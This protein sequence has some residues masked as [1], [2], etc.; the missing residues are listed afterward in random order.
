MNR[1]MRSS[2]ILNANK[3]IQHEVKAIQVALNQMNHLIDDQI[4]S[5]ERSKLEIKD[6]EAVSLKSNEFIK[7]L[8]NNIKKKEAEM[9]KQ[10]ILFAPEYQARLDMYKQLIE[11]PMSP[12]AKVISKLLRDRK[13]RGVVVYPHAVHWQP[14]QRPQHILMEFARKGYLCFFCDS[15]DTFT[16]DEVEERLFVITNQNHLLQALQTTHVL[17]INS[18]LLQNPW[19]ESLPHKTLWYDVLDRVD[20]FSYYD[21]NM[22]AKHYQ[23]LYD[24]DIVTYSAHQLKEYVGDREDAIYMPNA[25]RPED[26]LIDEDD[27]V[28]IPSELRP[29]VQKKKKI[30]GYYGAIEEWFDVE[31]VQSIANNPHVEIV[32]I[33]HWEFPEAFSR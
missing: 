11:S 14:I 15:A 18:Y 32:L 13:Y 1:G 16:I 29:L 4:G 8:R 23:V 27:K 2:S 25:A 6:L 20:F 5:L 9:S 12:E 10:D 28:D 17:V 26:F 31:L 7:Q 24:A 3:P 19:I 21:R 30:I 33:G 22:L